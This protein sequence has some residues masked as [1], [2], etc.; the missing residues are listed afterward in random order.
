MT[1]GT[2]STPGAQWG[3]SSQTMSPCMYGCTRAATPTSR[4]TGQPICRATA[5]WSC[6]TRPKPRTG[7]SAQTGGPVGVGVTGGGAVGSGLAVGVGLGDGAG[8]GG[9]VGI[10]R[11]V[12]G[13][14]RVGT[15]PA[16]V[17]VGVSDTSVAT[18]VSPDGWGVTV[19]DATGVERTEPTRPA[20]TGR[21]VGG[22]W[23]LY[24]STVTR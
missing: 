3:M 17:G 20:V 21:A 2:L 16:V 12:G 9:M 7:S 24:G 18:G 6:Q 13:G 8:F 15:S 19:T 4:S 1:Q 14:G 10:G 22:A 11:A 23:S 5:G